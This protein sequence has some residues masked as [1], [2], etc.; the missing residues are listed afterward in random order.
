MRTGVFGGTFDPPHIGHLIAAQDAREALRLD[1]V[2]LVPAGEPPHKSKQPISDGDIRR[3]MVE[4]AIADD[5]SFEVC[6]IELERR[7]ASYTVDTLRELLREFP[8]DSFFLLVGADQ[9]REFH[10]WREPEEIARLA[11]VVPLARAGVDSFP[12]LDSR[13]HPPVPVTRI[14]VSATDIRQR[15]QTGRSIRYLV[16]PAVEQL[17]RQHGLYTD[18]H[19][20][21]QVA[22]TNE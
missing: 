9:V 21:G 10:T 14:D 4:A 15:V 17:I 22:A 20:R 5:P 19:S 1:R 16:V 12:T 7:G 8:D 6:P 2:L 18:A 11:T 3:R 13:L